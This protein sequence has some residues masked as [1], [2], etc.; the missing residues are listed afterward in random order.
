LAAGAFAHAGEEHLMGTV[1]K[2]TDKSITIE[3]KDKKATEVSV[4]ADTKYMKGEANVAL[5]DIHVGDRVVV[6]A[7]KSGG[8]L[9]ATLIKIGVAAPAAKQGG[10]A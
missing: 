9:V 1:T 10:L 6:H 3:D 2:V 8:K 5:K 4:T 7:K